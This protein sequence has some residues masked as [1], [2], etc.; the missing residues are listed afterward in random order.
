MK[1]ENER[2]SVVDDINFLSNDEI[3]R[4]LKQNHIIFT[5][6][7][8]KDLLRKAKAHYVVFKEYI[9]NKN[10]MVTQAA[11]RNV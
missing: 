4:L 3:I 8:R 9:E 2:L 7:R 6:L 10:L 11:L 1:R 5:T